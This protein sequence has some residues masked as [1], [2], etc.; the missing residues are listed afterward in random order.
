MPVITISSGFGTGGSV[1]AKEVATSLGWELV[2]RAITV[3]VAAHLTVPLELAE[4]HDERVE[5]GWRRLLENLAQYTAQ[6]PESLTNWQAAS[7]GLRL[8]EATEAVLRHAAKHSAVIVGRASA[9]VLQ[10]EPHCLHVRLDGPKEARVRQGAKGLGISIRDA[11]TKLEQTDRARA[12][13]VRE[14]YT[15]DWRDPSL[16]HLIIDSTAFPISVCVQLILTASRAGI[17]ATG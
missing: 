17:G 15:R 4:A 8:R 14:M 9:I 5:T 12:A 16:Y 13:Y 1:I 11:E 3:D 7:D 2:N 6:V 10:D